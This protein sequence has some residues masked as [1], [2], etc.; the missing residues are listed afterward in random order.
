M[1]IAELYYFYP[2]LFF[3]GYCLNNFKDFIFVHLIFIKKDFYENIV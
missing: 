3:D 2:V 1:S